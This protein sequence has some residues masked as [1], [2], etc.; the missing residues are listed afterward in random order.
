[1]NE[2]TLY[3]TVELLKSKR[4]IKKDV[5]ISE[6]TG[7]SKQLVSNYINSKQKASKAFI[8]K[9]SEVFNLQSINTKIILP[10]IIIPDK[11]EIIKTSGKSI[12]KNHD[13]ADLIPYYDVDFVAGSSIEFIEAYFIVHIPA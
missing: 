10:E 13:S 12:R 11:S 3:D 7:Y 8:N 2:L 6:K 1:M 9:F 4:I 5:E